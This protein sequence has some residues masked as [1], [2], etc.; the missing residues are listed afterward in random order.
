VFY[1]QV[2]ELQFEYFETVAFYDIVEVFDGNNTLAPRIQ[3]LSGTAS[4]V[5]AALLS[6]GRTMFV[7]FTT[8][9]VNFVTTN[10]SYGFNATYASTFSKLSTMR[11][12]CQVSAAFTRCN[13][14]YL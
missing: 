9:N 13:L 3:L 4:G 14:S 12:L 1:V 11:E 6:T 8:P 10:S 2:V 7:T 5:I